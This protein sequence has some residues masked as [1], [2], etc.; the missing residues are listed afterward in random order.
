[1]LEN[2]VTTIGEYD[3]HYGYNFCWFGGSLKTL[4]SYDGKNTSKIH[5]KFTLCQKNIVSIALAISITCLYVE[6]K[7][8][9][10][11]NDMRANPPFSP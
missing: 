3:E 11:S 2:I 1:M 8:E 7:L 6:K 4:L 9:N 10:F 5:N